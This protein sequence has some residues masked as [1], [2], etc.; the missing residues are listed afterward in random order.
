[1]SQGQSL[2]RQPSRPQGRG[3]KAWIPIEIWKQLSP[4]AHQFLSL[5]TENQKT[6]MNKHDSISSR[7]INKVE[8]YQQTRNQNFLVLSNCSKRDLDNNQCET[9]LL[10]RLRGDEKRFLADIRNV[11]STSI[12]RSKKG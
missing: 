3:E 12:S 10:D 5:S 9:S 8:A 11:L 7:K 6:I 2:F 1:M 4:E